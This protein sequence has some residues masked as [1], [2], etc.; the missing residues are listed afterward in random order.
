MKLFFFMFWL[1]ILYFLAAPFCPWMILVT[2]FTI[3]TL[4]DCILYTRL[5]RTYGNAIQYLPY[6][7]YSL[8][9]FYIWWQIR[10][11]NIKPNENNDTIKELE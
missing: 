1:P 7:M 6:K 10:K 5:F 9:S 2:T 11:G 8:S 3:L 4:W